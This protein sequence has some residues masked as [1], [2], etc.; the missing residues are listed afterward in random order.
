VAEKLKYPHFNPLSLI[1]NINTHILVQTNFSILF[2]SIDIFA[3]GSTK[4]SMAIVD[5]KFYCNTFM[6]KWL[7]LSRYLA[8]G[9]QKKL[10]KLEF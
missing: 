1:S 10:K 2:R 9:H 7:S 3:F 4:I 8:K 5:G 6:I